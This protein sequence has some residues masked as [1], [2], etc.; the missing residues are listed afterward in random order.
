MRFN[1]YFKLLLVGLVI[2]VGPAA[3]PLPAGATR[4]DGKDGA[5]R[6][7]GHLR[8]ISW[9]N[10][11]HVSVDI[12]A[13]PPKL[14]IPSSA[15]VQASGSTPL[16][17][18][19]N[20][21]PV[22]FLPFSTGTPTHESLVL[23]PSPVYGPFATPFHVPLSYHPM[24]PFSLSVPYVIQR[25]PVLGFDNARYQFEIYH[26]PTSFVPLLYLPPLPPPPPGYPPLPPLPGRPGTLPSPSPSPK[27]PRL[28]KP[29]L[30]PTRKPQFPPKVPSPPQQPP[31]SPL[32]TP[33]PPITPAPPKAT[34]AAP[35]KAAATTDSQT[36]AATI[37]GSQT[38]PSAEA[39]A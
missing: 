2:G 5:R 3:E 31:K 12:T 25:H 10:T 34:R 17:T 24:P 21:H 38:T 19:P 37:A 23:I 6:A 30:P 36:T 15:V 22:D 1:I 8:S 28:P 20:Y 27:P 32:P 33:S 13:A 26:S 14:L 39:S 16:D 29:E 4:V 18:G 35:K 7:P 11:R 9:A